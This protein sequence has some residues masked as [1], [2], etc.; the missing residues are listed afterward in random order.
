L[1]ILEIEEDISKTFKKLYKKDKVHLEAINKKIS[2][3]L[4]DPYQ[5]NP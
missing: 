3:I 1:Y 2:Q 5:F 4:S